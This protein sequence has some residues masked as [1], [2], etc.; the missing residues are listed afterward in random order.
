MSMNS[1][2]NCN[3]GTIIAFS[4]CERKTTVGLL[5]CLVLV[6]IITLCQMQCLASER[7]MMIYT[8]RYNKTVEWFNS[9]HTPRKL[10]A[11]SWLKT[12]VFKQSTFLIDKESNQLSYD[13]TK[14][15]P[16]STRH[17][18]T[19]DLWLL[20]P[21]CSYSRSSVQVRTSTEDKL[22]PV[23]NLCCVIIAISSYERVLRLKTEARKA[24]HTKLLAPIC[25]Y[26]R[27]S[28]QVRT[29]T[30]DKLFPVKNLCCV[31]IAISSYE[32]VLRLKTEARKAEHTKYSKNLGR[33]IRPRATEFRDISWKIQEN[34][35]NWRCILALLK[36][37]RNPTYKRVVVRW[38]NWLEAEGRIAPC[39]VKCKKWALLSLYFGFSAPLV[40]SRLLFFAFLGV[41]S[42]D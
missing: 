10:F 36:E 35:N 25:S 18:A 17:S 9:K 22:F 3:L 38:R 11:D 12:I 1:F 30:E 26:S 5:I 32:R 24:E 39:H 7:W 2:I 29:S 19:R 20:A 40:V 34:Y 8:P 33:S 13:I 23:K 4:N 37:F 16:F 28:V 27:S 6:P 21:I 15:Q 41:F 42:G 14:A 31:I